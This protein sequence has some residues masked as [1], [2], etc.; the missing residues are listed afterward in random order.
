MVGRGNQEQDTMT[1]TFAFS[2]DRET[3]RGTF[4]SRQAALAA[5]TEELKKR[6]DL[7]AGIYIGQWAE[8]DPQSDHHAED[9]VAAMRDRFRAATGES[10]YLAK[11][12]EQTMADLDY[13]LDRAI[14]SWLSKHKLTAMPIKVRAVSEHPIPNVVHVADLGG[15][16][17]TSVIGEA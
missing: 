13:D 17:E 4:E 11:L 12:D 15:A 6:D 7:P 5:A 1:G 8:P 9:V 14:R 16:R 10:K 2:F 3:F